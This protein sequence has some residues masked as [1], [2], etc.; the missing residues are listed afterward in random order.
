MKD[1]SP[2]TEKLSVVPTPVVVFTHADAKRVA[3]MCPIKLRD[4]WHNI[5]AVG[6][7]TDM[8]ML[9]RAMGQ[10]IVTHH[11]KSKTGDKEKV[12]GSWGV[13][14][15]LA[16]LGV[17]EAHCFKVIWPEQKAPAHG[18]PNGVKAADIPDAFKEVMGET[19]PEQKVVAFAPR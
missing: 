11:V 10:M 8:R 19:G 18:A 2:L 6:A 5:I 9:N 13:S 17:G 16:P 4:D 14:V 12:D 7:M 3:E 1:N 15:M